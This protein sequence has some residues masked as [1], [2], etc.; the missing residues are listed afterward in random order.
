M[1]DALDQGLIGPPRFF[2]SRRGNFGV[3][4]QTVNVISDLVVHDLSILSL[5]FPDGPMTVRARIIGT[6]H[7]RHAALALCDIRYASGLDVHI[8]ANQLSPYKIRDIIV[9]GEQGSL[10]FDDNQATDKIRLTR[11]SADLIDAPTGLLNQ[12][13]TIGETLVPLLGEIEPLSIAVHRFAK[14]IRGETVGDGEAEFASAM[15]VHRLLEALQSSARENGAER[16][17]AGTGE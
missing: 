17:Y 4:H 9:G 3:Y 11:M 10:S 5:L 14:A 15:S 13:F 12:R 1:R 7:A 16:A 2:L 8:Q 6:P